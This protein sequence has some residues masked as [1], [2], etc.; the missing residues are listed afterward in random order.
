MKKTILFAILIP[1][2]AFA[3]SMTGKT[4]PE[5]E[6]WNKGGVASYLPHNLFEY[7]NGAAEV[8]LSY[9]FQKLLTLTYQN[10]KNQSITVDVYQHSNPNTGFG[11]YSQEKPEQGDF[12][13]I[14]TQGYYE[15][16]VLNF[17][18][19]TY[20][21]KLTGFDLNEND[22]S[23]LEKTARLLDKNLEGQPVFPEIISCFPEKGKI[24]NSERYILKNYLGHSFLN[25]AF[26]ADYKMNDDK[27]QIFI[28]ETGS[29]SEAESLVRSYLNFLENKNVKY[30]I[31]D[32]NIHRFQDPYYRSSGTMGFQ[33]KNNIIWGFFYRDQNL[34][35][36]YMEKIEQN[37]KS[38]KLI[39]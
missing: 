38:R 37:L 22:R 30:V 9:D 34:F 6:G 33:W 29:S 23:W 36:S 17:F 11:I 24:R 4:F 16:G 27:F 18:K 5:L 2:F 12:L 3:W 32:S 13:E 15:T 10:E 7:I 20:Y 26:V 25:S 8:Y 35:R 21:V 39:E 19:G 28:M 1:I 31:D 14:G